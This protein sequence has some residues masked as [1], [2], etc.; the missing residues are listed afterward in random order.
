M[1]FLAVDEWSGLFLATPAAE[2]M[3]LLCLWAQLQRNY[4][5]DISLSAYLYSVG[6]KIKRQIIFS[7]LK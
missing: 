3:D 7:Q 2:P 6:E 1:G 4:F 5:G